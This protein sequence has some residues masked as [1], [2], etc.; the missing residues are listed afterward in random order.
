MNT[1]LDPY[2]VFPWDKNFETGIALIDEQHQ[3]LIGILNKLVNT[4]AESDKKALN[5][6]FEELIDY[7]DFHFND[8]E[9]IWMNHFPDDPWLAS[10]Q[11]T[12]ASFLPAI[13]EMKKQGEL[14][15]RADNNEEIIK[16]LIRWLAFHIIDIDHRMAIA[17]KEIDAGVPIDEAKHIAN[18]KM[19]GSTRISIETILNLYEGLS[20]RT[21][22]MMREKKSRIN[23]EAKLK[24]ATE[25]LE[26][27][28]G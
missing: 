1:N 6:T 25:K 10:H 9:S 24:E 19:I 13:E 21:L 18:K 7:A 22:D 28:K 20:A 15:E 3:V 5:A 23:T 26:N 27:Q 12:H 2:V 11:S 17:V 16:Y 8:E 4:M 14:N